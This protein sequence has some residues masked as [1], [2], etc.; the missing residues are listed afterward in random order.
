MGE[1]REGICVRRYKKNPK[2]ES[3]EWQNQ[4]Q[5]KFLKRTLCLHVSRWNSAETSPEVREIEKTEKKIHARGVDETIYKL[6]YQL[7]LVKPERE[8]E[9]ERC[10]TKREQT[11]EMNRSGYEGIESFWTTSLIRDL[12]RGSSALAWLACIFFGWNSMLAPFVGLWFQL[13]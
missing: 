5:S 1:R 12:F 6:I 13:N 7:K 8:R 3:R 11:R 4:K 10:K 2:E 9:R